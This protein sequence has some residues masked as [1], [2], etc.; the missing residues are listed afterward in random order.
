LPLKK[1][2]KIKLIRAKR[3]EKAERERERERMNHRLV[4]IHQNC[5]RNYQKNKPK[6]SFILISK[7]LG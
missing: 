1:L 7:N 6:Y 3:A 4:K 2:T 5:T